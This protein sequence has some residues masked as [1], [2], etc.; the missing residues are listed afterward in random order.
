MS[1]LKTSAFALVLAVSMF[2]GP[3]RVLAETLM[4]ACIEASEV[5][6][7]ACWQAAGAEYFAN[8]AC[9]LQWDLDQT[10]CYILGILTWGQ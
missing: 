3:G 9:D 6:A 8:R 2:V 7:A 1:G 10:R 5:K 4:G